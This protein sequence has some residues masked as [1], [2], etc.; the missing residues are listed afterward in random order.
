MTAQNRRPS[1]TMQFI[2]FAKIPNPT[3]F[4]QNRLQRGSSALA[5]WLDHCGPRGNAQL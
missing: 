1:S 4:S 3:K 2:R 5:E